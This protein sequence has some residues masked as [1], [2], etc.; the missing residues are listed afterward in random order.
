MATITEML[1]DISDGMTISLDKDYNE[2]VTVPKGLS[3]VFD[4]G[5]HTW[6]APTGETPLTIEGA[7]ASVHNGTMTAKN[8]AVIR[9]GAKNSETE[10]YA[11]L[12]V[13]LN[14]QSDGHVCV[15]LGKGAHVDTS[16]S[17]NVLSENGAIQGNGTAAYF[18]NTCVIRDGTIRSADLAVYWPQ[19]GDLKIQGGTIIG[20]KSGVE[21]RAGS[22]TVS[23]GT[24]IG[25]GSPTEFLPNGSGSTSDGAGIAIAQHTTKK[26]I[27]VYICG[28]TI[29]GH[30][31]LYESNP[32]GNSPEDLAKIQ[33]YIA[34]GTFEPINNGTAAVYSED[35]KGFV[36]GGLYSGIV[37]TSFIKSGYTLARRA[38]GT[39]GV[40]VDQWFM[41]ENGAAGGGFIGL[42]RLILNK[43]VLN[44]TAGGIKLP[45]AG[46]DARMC[47]AIN[48][49]GGPTAWFDPIEQLLHI[50]KNGSDIDAVYKSVT[51]V[52]MGY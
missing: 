46:M 14:L 30:T 50:Y 21:I 43:A 4:L 52:L 19:E 37:D 51:V 1:S 41:P 26:H 17:M 23:G 12:G 10:S 35:C 13:T 11:T 5:G 33:I 25:E 20:K 15:F 45:L 31:P 3:V 36:S 38:D 40:V 27:D 48:A 9:V 47:M 32:Q 24:I 39:Y 7:S 28:G 6:T 29:K 34:A 22:L 2:S 44:Y 16:A 8:N 18:G 49:D 42:K